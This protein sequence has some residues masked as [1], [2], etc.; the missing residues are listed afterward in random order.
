M[1]GD[2]ERFV[3]EEF[4]EHA[5]GKTF[6][7]RFEPEEFDGDILIQT[8]VPETVHAELGNTRAY[9]FDLRNTKGK[10]AFAKQK[11]YL[12]SEMRTVFSAMT[13][14]IM[15]GYSIQDMRGNVRRGGAE[16]LP[17][18]TASQADKYVVLVSNVPGP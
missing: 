15:F 3:R 18:L 17:V 9:G 8:D 12:L 13:G 5:L 11:E 4:K 16:D 14:E 2:L 7:R 10:T 1:A 6:S